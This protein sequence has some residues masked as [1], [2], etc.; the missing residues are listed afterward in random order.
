MALNP[1]SPSTTRP[2]LACPGGSSSW[3]WPLGTA[4]HHP[5][6]RSRDRLWGRQDK[7]A[8]P[9]PLFLTPAPQGPKVIRETSSGVQASLGWQ[10]ESQ[11]STCT[12]K[13]Q[14]IERQPQVLLRLSE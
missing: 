5:G 4:A 14:V 8:C 11:H 1:V 2:Q 6:E 10:P 12:G 3:H 9:L 13:C 7:A